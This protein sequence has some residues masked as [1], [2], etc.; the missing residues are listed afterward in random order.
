MLCCIISTRCT[1]SLYYGIALQHPR[2]PSPA[3]ARATLLLVAPI[4]QALILNRFPDETADW[5]RRV[6]RLKFRRIIP[7]H[8]A[9]DLRATP[10]DFSRAFDFLDTPSQPPPSAPPPTPPLVARIRER[11]PWLPPLPAAHG[12]RPAPSPRALPGDFAL[13]TAA[14]KLCTQ[15]G[16]TAPPRAGPLVDVE[17]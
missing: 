9:N 11:I 5:V 6:S 13:L 1:S 14:S 17:S 12:V 4:L 8:L 15:I 10:A 3:Q 16:L 7:C 2:V